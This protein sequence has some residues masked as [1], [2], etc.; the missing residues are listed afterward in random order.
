MSRLWVVGETA[1]DGGLVRISAEIATLARSL[2]ES[3][4]GTA[5]GLVV[6]A[7]PARAATELATYLPRV[8]AV[9]EPAASGHAWAVVA[10]EH[11]S[12]IV[13]D[14]ERG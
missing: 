2:A 1:P 13:G 3:T 12:R 4:G 9:P 10:A 7:D 5:T 14:A 11:V 8:V 6:A